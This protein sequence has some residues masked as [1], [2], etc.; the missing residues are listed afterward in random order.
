MYIKHLTY[1]RRP[2]ARAL[3][4]DMQTR[5]G[6][7]HMFMSTLA[8]QSP[9]DLKTRD[10]SVKLTPSLFEVSHSRTHRKEK[11]EHESQTLPE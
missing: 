8:S 2:I 10:R 11:K 9:R 7:S 3:L 1:N 5:L 4:R 6:P